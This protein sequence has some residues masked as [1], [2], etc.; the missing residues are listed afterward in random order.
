[1]VAEVHAVEQRLALETIQDAEGA[2]TLG[3]VASGVLLVRCSGG[4][5]S[6]LGAQLATRL[7]AFAASVPT[8]RY[9]GDASGLTHY[10]LLARSAFV[11]VVM[12]QRKKFSEM[13]L[14]TWESGV[15]PV[16]KAFAAAIGE[17]VTV[18]TERADFQAQLLRAAPAARQLLQAH[19]RA[20]AL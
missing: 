8:L 19:A 16:T 7:A 15:T 4:M 10:D 13:V 11:R 20:V 18:V 12:A 2:I 6:A 9:F 5:S 1:M 14:L 17:P 3:W